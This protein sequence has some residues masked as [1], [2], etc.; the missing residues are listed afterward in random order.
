MY[1]N[2]YTPFFLF[3]GGCAPRTPRSG[4]RTGG[5]A[6][7]PLYRHCFLFFTLGG[8]TLSTFCFFIFFEGLQAPGDI[9]FFFSPNFMSNALKTMSGDL[10]GREI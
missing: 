2:I 4:G 10:P 7:D 6:G 3:L 5:R 1:I 9:S 8:S